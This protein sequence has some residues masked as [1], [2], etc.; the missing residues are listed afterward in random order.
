MTAPIPLADPSGTVREEHVHR[1][2]DCRDTSRCTDERC[3]TSRPA[4]LLW[5]IDRPCERCAEK[6]GRHALA[7]LACIGMAVAAC[8]LRSNERPGPNRVVHA[9]A[10]LCGVDAETVRGW[11]A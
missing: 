10:A 7:I 6:R 9:L 1:C 8:G 2:P 3:T 5:G 4:R 11:S